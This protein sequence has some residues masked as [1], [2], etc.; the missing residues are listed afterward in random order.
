MAAGGKEHGKQSKGGDRVP[1]EGLLERR[2]EPRGVGLGAAD[3]AVGKEAQV[4]GLVAGGLKD[5]DRE[6]ELKDDLKIYERVEGV[7]VALLGR[8]QEARDQGE[9][10]Q[11]G[12][13]RPATGKD[14]ED[15]GGVQA[16]GVREPAKEARRAAR[17]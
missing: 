15:D 4:R 13:R 16:E 1:A 3:F 17:R 9:R 7:V 2:G 10:N 6:A 12:D 5:D 11:A 8:V 14:G